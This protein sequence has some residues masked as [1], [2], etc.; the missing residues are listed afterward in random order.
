[1]SYATEQSVLNAQHNAAVLAQQAAEAA[2]EIQRKISDETMRPSV[3]Y[4]PALSVDGDQYCALYG[5]DLVQGVA[6][7]GFTADAAMRDF[8]TQWHTP[9]STRPALS[10]EPT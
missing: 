6:G 10:G 1:M 7:F 2:I 8:D 4:R 3:L 5:A 9:I